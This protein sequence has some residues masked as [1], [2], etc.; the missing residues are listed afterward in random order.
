M[1]TRE[2]FGESRISVGEC[3]IGKPSQNT[4]EK[5]FS[6]SSKAERNQ[7][8]T[9]IILTPNEIAREG[10]ELCSV[11]HGIECSLA[12]IYKDFRSLYGSDP[13]T[14]ANIWYD[15]NTTAIPEASLSEKEKLHGLKMF[16]LAMYFLWNY[17]R[18]TTTLAR[19]FKVNE[20]YASGRALWKWI[21]RIQA[22]KGTKI[23]WEKNCALDRDDRPLPK[24]AISVDGVDCK[25]NE[26]K[27]PTKPVDRKYYSHKFNHGALKYEL[28]IDI[29]KPKLVWINGPFQASKHDITVF[30][31][32]GLLEKMKT[33]HP[34]RFVVADRGYQTSRPDEIGIMS[35]PNDMDP[36]LLK[37]F[38]THVCQRHESFNGRIK[39]FKCLSETFRHTQEKHKIAF[40]A[41]CVIVQYQMDN[42]APIFDA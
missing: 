5:A 33:D 27:H 1:R 13:L 28:A 17:P 38:K 24:F 36:K 41:V 10:L 6:L 31:D 26:P 2:F 16:M 4:E 29:F 42:G 30:R 37:N 25:I 34:G 7:S 11:V 8:G 12:Q 19:T 21:A 22:L 35:T 23:V 18:N 9:M 40:E 20:K 39:F 15:M 14:V 3:A 32:H